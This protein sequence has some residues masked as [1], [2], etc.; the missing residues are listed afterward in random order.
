MNEK[1]MDHVERFVEGT[2]TY[3]QEAAD[4]RDYY[5]FDYIDELEDSLNEEN[6]SFSDDEKQEMLKYIENKLEE[7]Y[8]CDDVWYG[9][10]QQVMVIDGRIQTIP[11]Q[12]VIRF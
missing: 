7:E 2:I 6:I 12:L 9:S 10:P 3:A 5:G 1:Q 8:G 4:Y 11:Y